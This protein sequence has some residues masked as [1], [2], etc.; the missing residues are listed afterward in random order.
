MVVSDL[1]SR[2]IGGGEGLSSCGLSDQVC[3]STSLLSSEDISLGG[4]FD[5]SH[6][7]PALSSVNHSVQ[8]QP[9]LPNSVDPSQYAN[10]F[11]ASGGV[12]FN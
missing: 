3:P 1:T 6:S 11:S 9:L 8:F 5:P 4:A 10:H 12:L 2:N 7:F